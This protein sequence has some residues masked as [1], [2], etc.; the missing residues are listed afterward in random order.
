MHHICFHVR[1]TQE[2]ES[3]GQNTIFSMQLTHSL[4]CGG[5]QSCTCAD[6][7]WLV[8][9]NSGCLFLKSEKKKTPSERVVRH[10]QV[11]WWHNSEGL[12][13]ER[14]RPGA[15]AFFHVPVALCCLDPALFVCFFLPGL[16]LKAV[17]REYITSFTIEDHLSKWW[18]LF[19]WACLPWSSPFPLLLIPSSWWQWTPAPLTLVWTRSSYT[20]SHLRG[21]CGFIYDTMTFNC[22][23]FPLYY[24][25]IK[26]LLSLPIKSCSPLD[27]HK[28]GYV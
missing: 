19:C 13:L 28:M 8:G 6:G 26:A 27:I 17:S 23:N 24:F 10:A 3:K 5:F 12:V 22:A 25:I 20:P 7:H 1:K 2:R 21:V 11:W 14:A 9:E 16:F 18:M 4:Q 15:W